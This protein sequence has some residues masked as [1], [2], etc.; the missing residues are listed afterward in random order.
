MAAGRPLPAS[1]V[2]LG[3]VAAGLHAQPISCGRTNHAST[4][5]A[6]AVARERRPP[7][8]TSTVWEVGAGEHFGIH[9]TQKPAELF[10]RP[11]EWHTEPGEICLEPFSG[12]G[13]QIIA[14]ERTGRR[15]FAIERDPRYVDVAVLRWE[16]FTGRAA[17]KAT[18]VITCRRRPSSHSPARCA[19]PRELLTMDHRL[20]AADL[21]RRRRQEHGEFAPPTGPAGVDGG[22]T[23]AS[24][25]A[26]CAFRVRCV[27]S[28]A[29]T[30]A[31]VVV[32]KGA[33]MGL[34]EWAIN[35][36][37]HTADTG[38]AGRGNSLYVQ[39]GGANVGDFVQSRVNPAIDQS[40]SLARAGPGQRVDAQSR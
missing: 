21:V 9:P 40:P 2:D 25:S 20:R 14:A 29:T 17:V 6:K 16:S 24:A 22:A 13:T 19:R 32:M 5:G 26:R 23:A 31:Y 15:C 3:E 38:R 28:T 27:R 10:V 12:S 33:Q 18:A 11:I 7:P 36:A 30:I 35:M 8:G 39:P 1:A 37:L 4:A 34:S